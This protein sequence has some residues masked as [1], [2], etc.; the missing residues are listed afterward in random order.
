M[1]SISGGISNANINQITKTGQEW[2]EFQAIQDV[3]FN[4]K[5]LLNCGVIN[6]S[7]FNPPLETG[8]EGLAET[9]IVSNDASLNPINNISKLSIADVNEVN[10]NVNLQQIP[11]LGNSLVIYGDGDILDPIQPLTDLY[12]GG[13]YTSTQSEFKGTLSIY[14]GLNVGNFATGA[15]SNI[16]LDGALILNED[17]PPTSSVNLRAGTF[18]GNSNSL[19]ISGTTGINGGVY[20][21]FTITSG[22]T[23][24]PSDGY[25]FVGMNA[26]SVGPFGTASLILSNNSAVPLPTAN[27]ECASITC[28]TLNYNTL[29]PPL[30]G[31]IDL[32]G[33]LFNGN[34]AGGQ[35]IQNLG[36]VFAGSYQGTGT[37]GT[38]QIGN[39]PLNNYTNDGGDGV[40]VLNLGYSNLNMAGNKIINLDDPISSDEASNKNYVDNGDSA[41]LSSAEAYVN[42]RL[43]ASQNEYYSVRI[44]NN[45]NAQLT[46]MTIGAGNTEIVWTSG[47]IPNT[48]NLFNYIE[49][50]ASATGAGGG[51]SI[52][53]GEMSLDGGAWIPTTIG[54]WNTGANSAGSL[55]HCYWIV[56][57]TT[58]NYQLRIKIFAGF[59]SSI[60][61]N[62]GSNVI[63]KISRQ[64]TSF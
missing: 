42:G 29:N 25:K 12:C 55:Y 47:V 28:N 20:S 1:A 54:P 21:N 16:N 22:L 41:T 40:P 56:Q 5:N 44:P 31:S 58:N 9:L 64:L 27:L 32:S 24:N 60:T 7:S 4:N 51:A 2:S 63:L 52:I 11:E 61:I 18:S 46:P 35:N 53:L 17:G 30:L 19:I 34:N 57:N 8:A 10:V 37:N 62:S 45:P 59:G 23:L 38:F 49:F 48:F 3:D 13:L 43:Y 50:I 36:S 26:R 6:W 15:G 39:N 33:V 14:S